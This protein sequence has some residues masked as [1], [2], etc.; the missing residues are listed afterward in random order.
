M[1]W[2]F[3]LGMG[4]PLGSGKQWM[5]WI[6]IDDMVALYRLVIDGKDWRGAVNATAPEPT[7]QAEF[8][9]ALGRALRRPA[10][11]PAP[12]FAV[13]LALGEMGQKLLLEGQKVLPH[14]L[15]ESGYR[16]LYPD[17]AGALSDA[18]ARGK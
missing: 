16:F 6:H 9:K 14:R 13:R 17:L 5:S 12:S 15:Q 8:A 2:P 11:A 1:L 4:G 3:K 7:R 18:I 10:F